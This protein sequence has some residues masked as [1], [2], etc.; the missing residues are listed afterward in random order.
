[1]DTDILKQFDMTRDLLMNSIQTVTETDA[2]YMP[3]GFNNT[4]KWHV[5]HILFATNRAFAVYQSASYLPEHYA[6]LFKPGTSPRDWSNDIPAMKELYEQ[7]ERQQAKVREVF[8]DCM[9][10]KLTNPLRIA[11]YGGHEFL[12]VGEMLN[13]FIFHEAMHIGYINSF[14][15]I[16]HAKD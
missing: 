1:M 8:A 16:I 3:N 5:G 6:A 10:R 11:I 14:K 7:A 2:E 15:R 13:F 12:T 9:D 4:I